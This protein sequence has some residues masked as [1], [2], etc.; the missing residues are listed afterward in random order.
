[1]RC[2]EGLGA[3]YARLRQRKGTGK[4]M[5]AAARKLAVSVYYMLK[6]HK[7]YR[8][9]ASISRGSGKPVLRLGRRL[10]TVA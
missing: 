2:D 5:A 6:R 3:F 10:E 1:M 9:A 8:P 4:A 7:A